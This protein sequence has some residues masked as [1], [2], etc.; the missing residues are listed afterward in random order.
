MD[1]LQPA[2]PIL[3]GEVP[4]RKSEIRT[5]RHGLARPGFTAGAGNP[6]RP[7]T[8]RAERP[9]FKTG[10]GRCPKAA[11]SG[12]VGSATTLRSRQVQ[13]AVEKSQDRHEAMP[14][15]ERRTEVR[16]R[17]RNRSTRP[18]GVGRVLRQLERTT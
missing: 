8:P 10:R 3:A 1:R 2:D 18:T 17:V 14:P 11:P 7:K 15:P 12:G 9:G 16:D 4:Q 13:V 6:L 5:V